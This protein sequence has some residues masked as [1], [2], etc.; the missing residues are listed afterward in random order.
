MSSRRRLV[1]CLSILGLAALVPA[2]GRV[3]LHYEL[4]VDAIQSAERGDPATS[5]DALLA[6]AVATLTARLPREVEVKRAGGIGFTVTLPTAGAADVTKV[7]ALVEQVGRLEWR[8]AASA[9]Y[10][11]GD[12]HFQL[13]A[14]KERLEA[15]LAAGNRDKVLADPKALAAFHAD[16][17]HGPV[18]G[19]NL[20]WFVHR[21][22]ADPAAAGRWQV[23]YHSLGGAGLAVV[24]LF[25]DTD[26]NDGTIPPAWQQKPAAERVLL[27][28]V[29]VNMHELSF[30]SADLDHARTELATGNDGQPA[31]LYAMR[32]DKAAA[33]ADWTEKNAGQFAAMIWD[34]EILSLPR[35]I[36]RIPGKGQ[37]TGAYSAAEAERMMCVLRADPLPGM[38]RFVKQ[39]TAPK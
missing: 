27:E 14:E 21:V 10:A 32:G 17:E 1:L 29:A 37:L 3:A 23:A 15:W 24:P 34:G 7:R 18:A 25:A 13:A 16:A 36:G 30:S 12:V 4:P 6:G 33:Y 19:A 31:V 28:L 35:F 9:D 8:I 20:R 22:G 5:V 39:E 26:W 38:P 11:A 2:Q